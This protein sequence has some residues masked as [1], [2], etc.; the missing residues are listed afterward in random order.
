MTVLTEAFVLKKSLRGDFD[1]QYVLL[2]KELGKVRVLAKSA[3]KI[4]SKLAPHL[5]LF[6]TV[7]VM[8][9]PG[10]SFYRL[11]GAKIKDSNKN[12]NRNLFKSVLAN[13]FFELVDLLLLEKEREERVYNLVAEFLEQLETIASGRGAVIVFNKSLFKLLA[14]SGYEPPLVVNN[15]A[16]LSLKMVTLVQEATDKQLHSLPALKKI[17]TSA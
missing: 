16:E 15:Q 5:E 10:A 8:I 6:G 4:S 14:V 9:A 2:T 3:S 13:I 1:R 7:E 11:A 17:L 12:L